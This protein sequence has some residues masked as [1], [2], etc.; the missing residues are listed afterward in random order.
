LVSWLNGTAPCGVAPATTDRSETCG[1]SP[2]ASPL[3]RF[4]AVRFASA[5]ARSVNHM[6]WPCGGVTARNGTVD[7]CDAQG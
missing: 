4:D 7:Q 3:P 5:L 6:E 2:K 1:V